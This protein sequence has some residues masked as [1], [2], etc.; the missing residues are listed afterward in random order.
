MNRSSF[1]LLFVACLSSGAGAQNVGIGTLNPVHSPLEITGAVGRTVAVF[2]AD[3]FG[4]GAGINPP[5]L[6]FNYCWLTGHQ[7]IKSGYASLVQLDT[8]NGDLHFGN[9]NNTAGAGNF[10]PLVNYIT[11]MLIR[12]NGN[13]GIGTINPDFPLTVSNTADYKAM[14]ESP[15]GTGRAGFFAGLVESGVTSGAGLPLH[16]ATG[17]GIS[18]MQLQ[19]S[20]TLLVNESITINE[21]LTASGTGT[22]N[23]LPAALA[24][25]DPGG[26]ILSATP[27]VLVSKFSNGM[28]TISFSF[29]P[30]LYANRANYSF[31]VST[32]GNVNATSANFLF[33][34]DNTI[35]VKTWIPDVTYTTSGCSCGGGNPSLV[36]GAVTSLTDCV[37]SFILR[38][39]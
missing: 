9:F 34:A 32:E 39:K 26:N 22:A 13:T 30:N 8:Q 27:G 10:G 24:K 33:Q 2:G 19:V 28:Y 5:F 3:K 7:V 16:F 20:G 14:Q 18:R 15:D 29:E 31:Q 21:K 11:R 38:K 35:L 4:V 17:N 36:F 12:Q 37:F 25:V 6:G 23:L 1:L